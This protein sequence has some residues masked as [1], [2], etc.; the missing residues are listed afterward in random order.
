[1]TPEQINSLLIPIGFLVFF[2]LFAIRPQRKRDKETK[3]LRENLSIGDE[4]VTIGGIKGKILRVKDDYVTIE[5]GPNKI[6]L[7]ITR[8]SVGTVINSKSKKNDNEKK[9]SKKDNEKSAEE[10]VD[11]KIESDVDT[12]TNESNDIINEEQ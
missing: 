10:I 8:W 5:A 6:K 2:Y 4:I 12:T 11:K 7:E 9:E 3:E 1:M